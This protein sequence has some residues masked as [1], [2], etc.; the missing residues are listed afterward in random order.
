MFYNNLI[1]FINLLNISQRDFCR[2]VV[3]TEAAF[4]KWK[5]GN[6]PNA[7]TLKKI[8]K[9]F[10]DELK[11]PYEIFEDGKALLTKQFSQIVP[12]YP[13]KEE[14]KPQEPLSFDEIGKAIIN[15]NENIIKILKHIEEIKK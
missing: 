8:S 10:S 14:E 1:Y 12:K 9:Y 7:S 5:T 11:L 13:I 3:I 6:T 2:K 15:I 4:W